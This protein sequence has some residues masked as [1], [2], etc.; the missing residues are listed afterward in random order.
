MFQQCSRC[1]SPVSPNV[2]FCSNCGAQLT[3]SSSQYLSPG[4]MLQGRYRIEKILGEG[5]FGAV[6]LARD[7]R[8]DREC[9]V[10]QMLIESGSSP[11][12]ITQLQQGFEREAKSLVSLN[13]PGHPNIPEIYDFFAEPSGNYLVMKYIEG[14]NLEQ[15]LARTR[16]P[17]PWREA[18]GIALQVVSALDYMHS[19]IPD[20]VLHRDIKP[21]NILVD[22]ADRVWLVDFGLSKAQPTVGGGGLGKTT[23]AGTPGY[24]PLEQWL[25][26]A[27]PASD[28]YSLG[29][30]LH[31]LLTGCDP[32]D[33]FT[34]F[35]LPEAQ[36]QHGN[37][38]ALRSLNGALPVDLETTVAAALR[39]KPTDRPAATQWKAQLEQLIQPQAAVTTFTWKDGTICI[40][41]EQ[42]P[43]VADRCWDEA[44]DYFT[45]RDW[46]RW[47]QSLHHNQAMAQL[48]NAKATYKNS[49]IALDAFL[50]VLD[51]QFPPSILEIYPKALNFMAVP[52][53]QV[54]TLTLEIRNTGSGCLHGKLTQIPAWISV[55][56]VEFAARERQTLQL[57]VNTAKLSP[58]AQP[59]SASLWVD[60]GSVGRADLPVA[61]S[62]PLPQ[63][64]LS[65]SPLDLGSAFQ[66]ETLRR[67]FNVRN[68]GGSACECQ[69][70]CAEQWFSA[71]PASFRLEPGA[72]RD[73]EAQ[74]N[75]GKMK[76]GKHHA[77]INIQAKAARWQQAVNLPV[78]LD[79]PWLKTFWARY[80]LQTSLAV[81]IL[82]VSLIISSVQILKAICYSDGQK[83]LETGQWEQAAAQFVQCGNF[84]DAPTLVLESHY[85]YG[86]ELQVAG[87]WEGAAHQF[88]QC[89]NYRDAPAL[90]VESHYQYGLSAI[91]AED[92]ETAR[93][94]LEAGL[95]L[96]P[97]YPD[98]WVRLAQ[99]YDKV[100]WPLG[101]EMVLVP[102]GEFEMGSN[103]RNS[104]GKP[105][106]TVYLDAFW[107]DQTEVTNA[108]YAQCVA[109]G[110]CV[111][112]AH[113][114]SYTRD[115]YYGNDAYANY[116]V[117][118]VSWYNAEAYC[119]WAG[120]R[121]PTEAEWEKAARGTDGRTYPWGEGID[122]ERANY[123]SC[124][125]GTIE[126]GS[127]PVGMSP[128]GALDMAG[129]VWEWVA[130][131]H[132]SGYYASSQYSNPTG[133]VS[134]EYR[135][136]RGGS[137]GSNDRLVSSVDRLRLTPAFSRDYLGFRC[138]RSP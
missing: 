96:D 47:F 45:G 135:V 113:T 63:L 119:V 73:V 126:V 74:V 99:I 24:A 110:Y 83:L 115:N 89:G 27:V 39:A 48:S 42:L 72:S 22:Q 86:E 38:P 57:T 3:S 56:K 104:S 122:C 66:G 31:H 137:W 37:F 62:V 55:D 11:S 95:R 19:R 79:L 16:Q 69:V 87:Q 90:V 80:W 35:D 91:D 111:T 15:R 2:K 25:Q 127:Y 13:K 100:G 106:H 103:D 84:R 102:A 46:E 133:P 8:L 138:A 123:G 29:A 12:E 101:E 33:A 54:K 124:V 28:M 64:T 105:V 125:G 58:A 49:D 97:D 6:Y 116:P 9:V 70:N 26:Q 81:V 67:T 77:Q 131:W 136:L 61:V 59:H 20:P 23:A 65:T 129:N 1:N 14:E 117:I 120:R 36:R 78:S 94:E 128:Y 17:L 53:E 21:A 98:L 7:I 121:L 5:G 10:K 75:T 68:T 92:W 44:R 41:P 71:K 93:T 32:R 88:E 30:T 52:W 108:M 107:M 18:V 114:E 4:F 130:D 50:R 40:R 43:P 85:R 34:T 51:P 76:L 109:A 132:D 60:A 134:G 82:L 112:P 118:Y